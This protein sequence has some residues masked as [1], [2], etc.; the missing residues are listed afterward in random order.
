MSYIQKKKQELRPKRLLSLFIGAYLPIF[1]FFIFAPTEIFFT[2]FREFDVVFKEFGWRFL[3]YGTLIA[4]IAAI[5]LF[6]LPEILQKILL[7]ITW[8]FSICGYIQTLFLNQNMDLI[9]ATT[10]GYEPTQE[11]VTKNFIIW[12]VIAVVALAVL[13]LSKKHWRKVLCLTSF[14]IIAMQAVAYISLFPSADKE[15]FA[16]KE[17]ELTLD[18]SERYTVS[19]EGNIIVFILDTVSNAA[20]DEWM[21]TDYPEAEAVLKD[22]TYYKNADSCDFGTFPTVC[23]LITGYDFDPSYE[24][25]DYFR[26]SWENEK[27]QTFY[28]Q[29]HE[30]GYEVK[31]Y[32]PE[33]WLFVGNMPLTVT[34]GA[35]DNVTKGNFQRNIDYDLLDKTLLQM[36]C[37]RFLPDYFKPKFDVPNSQ[38]AAIANRDGNI[39]TWENCDFY[40]ELTEQGL[41]ATDESKYLIFQHLNGIHELTND[42]D[43]NRCKPDETTISDSMLGIWKMLDTYLN[44]LKACGAYDNSTIII[45]ADHGSE[46]NCQPIFFIKEA[47]VVQDAT[48]TSWDA[49]TWNEVMPT[50]A[51]AAGQDPSQ[52]GE[53]IYDYAGVTQRV[54]TTRVRANDPDYPL[55]DSYYGTKDVSHLVYRL[56]TYAGNRDDYR[57]VYENGIYE[58]VPAVNAYY[59]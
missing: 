20:Y 21:L 44:D 4:V 52:Y 41:T 51:Q 6:L 35:I 58:T 10:F 3:G 40:S 28:Q 56:Y 53:T 25:V 14:I 54:R 18:A 50:I 33:P 57:F 30:D 32:T 15:A 5:V 37:Y 24:V 38:Y 11:V 36:A 7:G 22:F 8:I 29:L 42:K 16:Y 59:H 49:I 48:V 2:N 9:G 39:M 26:Q 17:G 31:V 55:V 13:I 27:T 43:C 47:G 23:H 1:S 12:G 19:S 46:Y 34:N 45:C